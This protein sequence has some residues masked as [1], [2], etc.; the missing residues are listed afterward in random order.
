MVVDMDPCQQTTIILGKPFLK[1]VKATID[2]KRGIIN[3]KLDGVREKFIYHPKNLACYYQIRV[4]RYAGSRRARCVEVLPKHMRSR[5]QSWNR[6]PQNAM[7]PDKKPSV[8]ENFSPK[9]SQHVKNAT[10]VVTSS[11]VTYGDSLVD[12]PK[13]WCS[14]W[15]NKPVVIS[16]FL[17]YPSS[18]ICI[19]SPLSSS[20]FIYSFSTAY[21]FI[22][23][24]HLIKSKKIKEI[25]RSLEKD[26]GNL[27]YFSC[28]WS[29]ERAWEDQDMVK[30]ESGSWVEAM[31]GHP[32]NALWLA[33]HLPPFSPSFL[34]TLFLFISTT[35]P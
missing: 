23:S 27:L 30:N 31:C 22:A 20:I 19:F 34:S 15:E 1:L 26:E 2:K 24:L 4:H 7:T 35:A 16:Y 33:G 12:R 29:V 11:P 14:R 10:S 3:M 32:A 21:L 5:P 9:F 6:R 18:T 17:F 8:A 28:F 13:M 25:N